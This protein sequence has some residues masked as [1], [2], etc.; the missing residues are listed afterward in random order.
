MGI[1]GI[2]LDWKRVAVRR[3]FFLRPRGE[4]TRDF[5]EFSVANKNEAVLAFNSLEGAF[6]S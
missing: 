2:G 6:Y 4:R 3:V 5:T 1:W